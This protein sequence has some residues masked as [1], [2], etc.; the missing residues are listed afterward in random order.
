MMRAD[1]NAT[2]NVGY[3][4]KFQDRV[5]GHWKRSS[6][7][8]RNACA[9][10]SGLNAVI[11]QENTDNKKWRSRRFTAGY[12]EQAGRARGG[13]GSG[14]SFVQRLIG[15]KVPAPS[16]VDPGLKDNATQF[17]AVSD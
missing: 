5:Y 12:A 8:M 4:E 1:C 3:A 6:E 11:R 2:F 17:A 10:A 7:S 15:I 9:R 14:R 16:S 13:G